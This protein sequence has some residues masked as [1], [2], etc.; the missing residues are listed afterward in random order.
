MAEKKSDNAAVSAEKQTYKVRIWH[1]DDDHEEDLPTK[2]MTLVATPSYMAGFLVHNWLS[3][4]CDMGYE[5]EVTDSK[6]TIM[7][8]H[9][10]GKEPPKG[11]QCTQLTGIAQFLPPEWAEIDNAGA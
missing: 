11:C 8:Y 3:Q 4:G 6:G 9:A 2:T 5:L 10:R 1:P 7:A